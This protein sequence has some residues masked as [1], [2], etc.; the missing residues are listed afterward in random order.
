MKK[1]CAREEALLILNSVINEG[2]FS[3][4]EIRKKLSRTDLIRIDKALVTEIVNG[5]LRNLTKIDWVINKFSK[6]KTSE[7]SNIVKGVLRTAIYQI[8]FLDRVPDSAICNESVKL[9]K[10]YANQRTAN[11]VNGVLR[12]I[13]RNKDNIGFPKEDNLLEYLSIKYSHP[14]WLVDLWLNS[15]G[16]EFTKELLK[17]NNKVPP[18]TIRVNKLKTS[19]EDLLNLLDL[20]NISWNMG[21]YNNEAISIK[22]ISSLENLDLFKKGYFQIQD[23]SSM[24][25][26]K[27]LDPKPG[28]VVIDV[29]SGPGGK[30]THIA[31][32]ILDDG[33]IIA[34]DIYSH[35]LKLIKENARRLGSTSIKAELFNANNIDKSLIAKADAVLVD[36]PCSGLGLVR[37]KPD[38]RWKKTLED[39]SK[40]SKIQLK[41]LNNAS[42]YVKKYGTLVYCTCTLSKKE[43][44]DL[45][46]KFLRGNNLF[47]LDDISK[48]LPKNL[49][50]PNKQEGYVE[51]YPNIHATDGFFIAR[52]VR[53]Q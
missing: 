48:F 29:C 49:E 36:A 4:I 6:I 22:G 34:R 40:L 17:S 35:K 38:L 27:I 25:A 23:E 33:V 37:R 3:D 39:I 1:S 51:L 2:A 16:A 53:K 11:F 20:S 31:E 24:L 44:I 13:I 45:I 12:N 46:K 14:L 47:V 5:T 10:K 26:S 50:A 52:M 15:Y 30:A 41:I 42:L 8:L 28:D 18:L 9:T 19:K 7:L 32:I 21:L 43:N